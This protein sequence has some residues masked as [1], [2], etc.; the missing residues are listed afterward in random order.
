MHILVFLWINF[1]LNLFYM[2]NFCA[3]SS[4]MLQ[5]H[6]IACKGALHALSA[7]IFVLSS[8]PVFV[9]AK[10]VLPWSPGSGGWA[11]LLSWA[12]WDC[13]NQRGGCW[14]ATT[15][16]V[17]HRQWTEAHSPVFPWRSPLFLSQSFGLRRRLPIWQ[18]FRGL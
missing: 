9:A 18:T 5:C 14:W 1:L 15:P 6:S 3:F 4:T 10:G 2:L 17:R 7:L 11:S 8:A 16:R 12:P 13:G